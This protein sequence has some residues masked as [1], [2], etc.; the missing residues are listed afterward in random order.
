M[1]E[2]QVHLRCRAE[3]RS[4]GPRRARRQ[5]VRRAPLHRR[6][7]SLIYGVIL[8]VLGIGASDAE[9]D[10]AAGVN[11]NLWTGLAML[12]VGALFIAWA[13]WRP[14]GQELAEAE[15]RPSQSRRAAG[16]GATDTDPSG[17]VAPG[18][19]QRQHGA[20][21]AA[22]DHAG[23]GGSGVLERRH[24]AL[25]LGDGRLVV[26]AQ[27]GVRGVQQGAGA[28]EVAGGERLG[29]RV[30]ARVLGQDVAHAPVQRVRQAAGRRRRRAGWRSRAPRRPRR[31]PRGARCSRRPRAR[32]RRPSRA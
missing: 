5:P 16:P 6:R 17:G 21:E 31:T 2:R 24:R 14:L 28:L 4:R 23:A 29:H 13:L 22:A 18:G 9:V 12:L 10:K 27:A 20:A 11:V 15:P 8:F 19:K 26:V 32:A 1:P 7:C 3:R 30:D 25:D